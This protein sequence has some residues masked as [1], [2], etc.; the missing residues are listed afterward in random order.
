MEQFLRRQGLL[1]DQG[2]PAKT[3]TAFAKAARQP[4][5]KRRELP[6]DVFV[7]AEDVAK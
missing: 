5:G 2:R 3:R 7:P 4:A 6:A 1:P